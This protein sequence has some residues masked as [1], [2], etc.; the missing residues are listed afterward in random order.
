MISY[1]FSRKDG[2]CFSRRDGTMEY[3]PTPAEVGRVHHADVIAP[4]AGIP[5]L[6]VYSDPWGAF[7]CSN[8]SERETVL[9]EVEIPDDAEIAGEKIIRAYRDLEREVRLYAGLE[10]EI[11]DPSKFERSIIFS[12]CYAAKWRKYLRYADME[13]VM[14]LVACGGALDTL[15]LHDNVDVTCNRLAC[16]GIE[17]AYLNVCGLVSEGELC[18]VRA[19]IKK[20]FTNMLSNLPTAEKLTEFL[21]GPEAQVYEVVAACTDPNPAVALRRVWPVIERGM[22]RDAY[23]DFMRSLFNL[24]AT[25]A[26]DGNGALKKEE[27]HDWMERKLRQIKRRSK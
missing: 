15:L 10:L 4:H 24:L 18:F 20:A 23:W 16:W 27:L 2:T 21:K 25:K 9:W 19:E 17:V 6:L 12:G 3:F 11:P 8:C 14:R 22:W 13:P 5:W 7:M 1:C 26:L